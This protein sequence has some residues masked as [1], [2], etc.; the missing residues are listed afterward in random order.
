MAK[1]SIV[2]RS[3]TQLQKKTGSS[4]QYSRN[5]DP[6]LYAD[7]DSI[8]KPNDVLRFM[9]AAFISATLPHKDIQETSFTRTNGNYKMTIISN[10][11]FGLP[12]GSVS[13]MVLMHWTTLAI[14]TKNPVLNLGKNI[15]E[16]VTSLGYNVNGGERG[17]ITL[18]KN[19]TE[20]L[21]TS[22]FS[23]IRTAD[24]TNTNR[25]G[26]TIENIRLARRYSSWFS[27]EGKDPDN[28]SLWDTELILDDDLFNNII[29]H[30]VPINSEAL[31]C[32]SGSPLAMD[33]YMWA[34][35]KNAL[36]NGNGSKIK[37]PIDSLQN[38]FGTSYQNTPQGKRDFKKKFI[39]SLKK[40]NI[41]YEDLN[42]EIEK[43][44][45]V[46]TPT[47]PHVKMSRIYK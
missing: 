20:R 13:R 28:N 9:P 19:Q 24:S 35:Y 39:V 21:V 18:V 5:I 29:S 42:A 47:H 12:F 10:K 36:Y 37:I 43:D 4:C 46:F 34:T 38:Q 32:L 27:S 14:Q 31:K 41:I 16:Y 23:F 40:V 17:S 6:Y 8:I 25:S 45:L 11:E 22:L 44:Y 2:P 7:E 30:P 3:E 26:M 1:Q 33:I 15:S